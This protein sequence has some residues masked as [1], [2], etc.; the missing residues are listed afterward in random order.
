VSDN[1][2]V[3]DS[4]RIFENAGLSWLSAIPSHWRLQQLRYLSDIRFSNVDKKSDENELP[5]QLCNYT[6][7]YYNQLITAHIAFME[8]TATQEEIEKFGLRAGDVLVTKDSESWDD[9]AIPAYVPETLP[10]VICG[11][12]LALI[13]ADDIQLGRFLA[14]AF[15][16]SAVAYQ[17]NIAASGITRYGLSQQSIKDA[18]FPVPPLAEQRAI[19]DFL[20]RETAQ[21]DAL[22]ARKQRLLDLLAERRLALITRAVTKGLDSAAPMKD[23]GIEWLGEIPEHWDVNLFKRYLIFVEQG[24]SPQC[25]NTPAELDEWGVLKVGCVNYGQ[26][27]PEENKVLP[28]D[29]EPEVMYEIQA[30]DLLVS[31]ANTR[32]LLGSAAVVPDDVRPRLLLCDKL[33]RLHLVEVKAVAT[34][35]AYAMS[36]P[37]VRLQ[38]EIDA[39]GASASMQNISQDTISNLVLAVPPLAE[40]VAIAHHLEEQLMRLD[41]LIEQVKSIIVRLQERRVALINEAVTGKIR[42]TE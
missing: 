22:I 21:I 31:R 9:I 10:N 13:R 19:A 8:A 2:I 23:S 3:E 42:V 4:N 33:Y 26:F 15:A 34:F 32:E 17:F 6:D 25:E 36:T 16:S 20:D 12:H 1:S 28:K 11:Y 5:V 39:T 18:W 7:V 24:W 14:W 27:K 35:L 38:I 30:G 37:Y 40:Q 41:R 29:V